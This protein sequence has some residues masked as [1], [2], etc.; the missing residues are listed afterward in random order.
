MTTSVGETPA[1]PLFPEPEPPIPGPDPIP[2][3]IPDPVPPSR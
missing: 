3:P 2:D 1:P